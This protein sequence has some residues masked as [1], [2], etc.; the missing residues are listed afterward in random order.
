[1]R[2]SGLVNTLGRRYC[3]IHQRE[4]LSHSI[5]LLSLE[6]YVQPTLN[7]MASH[8]RPA[9]DDLGKGSKQ[10]IAAAKNEL[11]DKFGADCPAGST[12][13]VMEVRPKSPVLPC[14]HAEIR[15]T[16]PG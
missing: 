12:V 15:G 9:I 7:E 14:W 2:I 4:L 8:L 5:S 10:V 3:T 16:S 6:D 13:P 1:M 11:L